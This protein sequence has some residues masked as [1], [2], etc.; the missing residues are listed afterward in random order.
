MVGAR[1]MPLRAISGNAAPTDG[2]ATRGTMLRAKMSEIA[3][4]RSPGELRQ[5]R[6]PNQRPPTT[7]PTA[8]MATRVPPSSAAPCSDA[9]AV[10]EISM[11]PTCAHQHQDSR[12]AQRP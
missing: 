2:T 5:F 11:D 1:A 4:S 6:A 7:L 9:K 3:G 10:I 12:G 8:W